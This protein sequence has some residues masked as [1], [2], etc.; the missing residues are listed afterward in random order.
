MNASPCLSTILA[1]AAW[2]A[3]ETPEPGCFAAFLSV[4]P[5]SARAAR[6]ETLLKIAFVRTGKPARHIVG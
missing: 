1:K 4:S 3:A 2:F 6:R 5:V